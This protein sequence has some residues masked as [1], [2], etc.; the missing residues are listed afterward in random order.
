MKEIYGGSLYDGIYD[1]LGGI[2]PVM[3]MEDGG[4]CT[5]WLGIRGIF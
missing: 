3:G 1:I 2:Y 4:I 5:G